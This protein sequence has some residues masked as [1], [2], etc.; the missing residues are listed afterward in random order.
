MESTPKEPQRRPIR[1]KSLFIFVIGALVPS[2]I[3]ELLYVYLGLYE[4]LFFIPFAIFIS[5]HYTGYWGIRVRL[6]MG[7]PII[8]AAWLIFVGIAVPVSD[9]NVSSF[10]E[11]TINHGNV[12]VGI[13]PYVGFNSTHYVYANFTGL[14]TNVTFHPEI[15]LF[16]SPDYLNQSYVSFN[17]TKAPKGY[18]NISH[19]FTN[20]P[21][22]SFY[23]EAKLNYT[24]GSNYSTGFV[25]GPINQ[26][27]LSYTY[28]MVVDYIPLF[29]GLILILYIAGL[30]I[31]KSISNSASNRWKYYK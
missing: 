23:F 4:V 28:S 16:T 31:A 29:L 27:E 7:L 8:V 12:T 19:E 1:K 2:V 10:S 26:G 9:V 17:N 30:F 20:I 25:R 21:A 15:Y 13:S 6:K 24:G 11:P 14:P 3:F 5:L 22:G 18:V